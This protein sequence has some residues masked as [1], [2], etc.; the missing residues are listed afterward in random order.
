MPA[1]RETPPD[2]AFG[3]MSGLKFLI[4]YK[5][6]VLELSEV[7]EIHF[8]SGGYAARSRL[9][10]VVISLINQTDYKARDLYVGQVQQKTILE[11]CQDC[12]FTIL[13]YA[14][15][16]KPVTPLLHSASG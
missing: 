9:G 10:Q 1:N 14:I 5:N 2:V 13:A 8:I 16:Q 6:L 7:L 11:T 15:K 12:P 3:S 4:F